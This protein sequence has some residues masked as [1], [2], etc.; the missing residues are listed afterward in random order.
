MFRANYPAARLVRCLWLAGTLGL[1]TAC[2]T[3]TTTDNDLRRETARD[4]GLAPERVD[5]ADAQAITQRVGEL[6]AAPLARE[7]AVTLAL[8]NN[9][10]LARRWAELRIDA[11]ERVRAS[12]PPNPA[13]HLARLQRGD[14]RETERGVSIDLLGLLAWPAT[15]GAA[16]RHYEAARQ[17][18]LRDALA[19]A[20]DAR[21]AWTDAVAA[22]STLAHA[23]ATADA[24]GTARLYAERLAAAG[25]A[26][27][28][29][30]RRAQAFDAEAGIALARAQADAAASREALVRLLGLADGERLQLPASLPDLPAQ[31]LDERS[32]SQR[33]IDERPDVQ[34]ARLRADATARSLRLA[35]TT[36]VINVL[37]TGYQS[38][39]SNE[40]PVQTGFEVTLELPLF[41]FGSARTSS[42]RARWEAAVA[43]VTALAVRAQSQTREAWLRY[44]TSH[45]IAARYRDEVLP[46]STA[47]TREM[48][49]RHNGMLVGPFELIDQAHAQAGAT[50]RWQAA[51]RDFWIADAQLAAVLQG[52]GDNAAPAHSPTS[53][54]APPRA[55][56]H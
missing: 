31:P 25:N 5:A 2:A 52:S 9:P 32:A 37:E 21:I 48:I 19:L 22:A 1:L 10:V 43:D 7:D 23:R 16:N 12:R 3:S 8:L 20:R 41:D 13:L 40:A 35:R 47:I 34:A 36:R 51:L 49:L 28:L 11:A 54:L 39:R 6:L 15:R 56:A 50:A 29:A 53:S 14:E 44:R 30:A 42:A 24:A 18:A 38:N 33:A 17:S 55:G 26:S 27:A 45:D 4:L 46:A